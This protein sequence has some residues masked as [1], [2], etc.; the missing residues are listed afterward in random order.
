MDDDEKIVI[1][2][3]LDKIQ[4]ENST[5]NKA[6]LIRETLKK[7]CG[8]HWNV[9]TYPTFESEKGYCYPY[10]HWRN[11]QWVQAEK[12]TSTD[13]DSNEIKTFLNTEFEW[14]TIKDIDAFQ[15]SAYTKVNNKFLGI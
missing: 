7:L 6:D 12:T 9:I 14:A 15:Q 11:K 2:G 8:G 13:F 1:R 10:L 3:V 5:E 4:D